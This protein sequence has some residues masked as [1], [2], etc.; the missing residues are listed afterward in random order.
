[1]VPLLWPEER[2]ISLQWKHVAEDAPLM[3]Y[4]KEKGSQNGIRKKIPFK[5][6]SP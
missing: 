6:C 2:T 1:L 4:R 3:E 5:A